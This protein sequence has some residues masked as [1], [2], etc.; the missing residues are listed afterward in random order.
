MKIPL[1]TLELENYLIFLL[2]YIFFT[3]TGVI[4]QHRSAQGK[5]DG[6]KKKRI[7]SFETI[8]GGV[9]IRPEW[10]YSLIYSH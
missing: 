4:L 9:Q 8:K 5:E 10:K 3:S 2:L 7:Y 6:T 1:E